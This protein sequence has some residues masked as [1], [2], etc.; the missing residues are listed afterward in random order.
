MGADNGLDLIERADG[1]LAAA[2]GPDRARGAQALRGDAARLVP[3]PI[4]RSPIR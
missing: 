2:G 1:S 3:P 4:P